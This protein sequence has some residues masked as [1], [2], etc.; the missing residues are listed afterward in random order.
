[1]KVEDMIAYTFAVDFE[2]STTYPPELPKPSTPITECLKRFRNMTPDEIAKYLHEEGVVGTPR[3]G[4]IC[5]LAVFFSRLAERPVRVCG[6]CLHIQDDPVCYR[7]PASCRLFVIQFDSDRYPQLYRTNTPIA[8][9][10]PLTFV[11]AQLTMYAEAMKLSFSDYN[12]KVLNSI[13]F[14]SEYTAAAASE[15]VS[16]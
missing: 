9:A 13:Q 6:T 11:M 15:L 14:T 16:A 3:H 8:E 12:T 7:L 4:K 5:A 2:A 10:T 1:M